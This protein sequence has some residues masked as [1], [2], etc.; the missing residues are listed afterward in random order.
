MIELAPPTVIL[1]LTDSVWIVRVEPAQLKLALSS[2]SPPVPTRA[3][4]PVVR[5]VTFIL[6]KL[7]SPVTLKTSP[8]F[9]L[10]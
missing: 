7:T 3:K 6:P 5:S 8:E 9:T 4:R 1:L 10:D 2:S